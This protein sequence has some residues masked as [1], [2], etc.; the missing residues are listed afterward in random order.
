MRLIAAVLRDLFKTQSEFKFED[1]FG[2]EDD[3]LVNFLRIEIVPATFSC[4]TKSKNWGK[5]KQNVR[6]DKPKANISIVQKSNGGIKQSFQI[7]LLQS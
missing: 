2:T 7:Y 1:D 4:R 5:A 6:S 3:R